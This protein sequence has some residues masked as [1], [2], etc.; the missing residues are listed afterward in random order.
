M[1]AKIRGVFEKVPGSGIWWICY[2]DADGRKRREKV[3]TRGS[4]IQLYQKRKTEALEGKKLPEKLRAR[5][6]S[7]VELAQDA[8]DYSR[9][10]KVSY[11]DDVLRMKQVT[12]VFG[13]RAAHSITPQDIERWFASKQRW[14][15][16]TCNRMKA[17]FSL[18]YRL[19]IENGKVKVNPAHLVKHRREN[20]ARTRFLT[21]EEEVKLRQII[22]NH[23]PGR[24]PELEIALHTGMRRGEQYGL[25]W[26]CANFEQRVLTIARS[27]HG[28]K[29]H[30]FLNDTAISALQVL[31]KFSSGQGRIFTNGYTSE[32]TKGAREWFEK[33]IAEAGIKDFTWHCL[34]HTFA[35]RLVMKGIDIRT[36]QELMGHKTIQMTLRYAHLAPQHQLDAVQRLCDPAPE[37]DR[38]TDTRS[39]TG[40]FRPS[41]A[42]ATRAS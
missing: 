17:L 19:A 40:G 31:S 38:A 18:V 33:C 6:A 8:L 5:A 21:S 7:F 27:K 15:P 39:D 9:A 24:L 32:A 23:Y 29:R 35:S 4:A 37:S 22:G 2:F 3:G 12:E 11:E 36:V 42:K 41:S 26:D 1:S 25:T 34:R 16:A 20:N 10:H 14:K 30:V 13:S 28:E